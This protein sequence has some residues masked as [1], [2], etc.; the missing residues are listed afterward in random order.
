M[1]SCTHVAYQNYMVTKKTPRQ[2]FAGQKC[3]KA[4]A[5]L[6]FDIYTHILEL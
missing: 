2:D 1:D 3:V 5:E 6:V 4:L